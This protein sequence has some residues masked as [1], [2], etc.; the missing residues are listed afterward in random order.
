MMTLSLNESTR[1]GFI[2]LDTS[3]VSVFTKMLN[4]PNHPHHVPRGHVVAGFPGGSKDFPLSIDRVEGFTTELKRDWGV[5]IVD[6]PEAVAEMSDMLF[7]TTCDGR[8]HRE[9]FE[10]TAKFH[11]PTF[12]D[13]P[14][15]T[16]VA[17]AK[18]ILDL[19]QRESIPLM[20][21]SSLRY[22]EGLTNAL[23]NGRDD[24]KACDI[25]GPMNE[26]PTQ[27]GWFWYGCHSVEMMVSIMGANCCEVRCVRTDNSD[28]LTATWKDGRTASIRGLRNAHSKFGVTLH[29]ADG[30]TSID[31]SAGRPYYAGMLQ[32]IMASL[33]VDKS[34]VPTDEMLRI[35]QIMEAANKS[36]AQNGATIAV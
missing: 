30:P 20:S 22:S 23:K 35:V 9:Y 32:A 3:H 17:D 7:I 33:T 34:D 15:A 4:D 29:R 5:E 10:R 21:C 13:K 31:A 12:I 24:V 25:Y 11:R 18:A 2:G 1:I 26:E 8:K 27:P 36:R 14:L 19:A 16:T 28:L 6:S